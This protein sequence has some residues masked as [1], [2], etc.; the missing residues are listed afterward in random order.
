MKKNKGIKDLPQPKIIRFRQWKLGKRWLYGAFVLTVL[1]GGVVMTELMNSSLI[2]TIAHA[3]ALPSD[4]TQVGSIGTSPV[5]KTSNT[6]WTNIQKGVDA[7]TESLSPNYYV[8]AVDSDGK[9][10]K[11]GW[12]NG[13]TSYAG[14]SLGSLASANPAD[15]SIPNYNFVKNAI[16]SRDGFQ[17]VDNF[18]YINGAGQ[19][20]GIHNVGQAFEVS[21]GKYV[22]IG[23]KITIN[24]ATYY[25]SPGA[26]TPRDVFGDGYK[27]MVAARNDGSGN[28]TLG[29]VVVMTGVQAVDSGGGSEGGGL[30]GGT[31]AIYGGCTLGIPRM[32]DATVTY[33]NEE[34][35]QALPA[36]SLSVVKVADVDA[37]QAAATD[38]N[39]ALGY[40]I[41]DPT[42][43]TLKDNI[44]TASTKNTISQD[45]PTLSPNSYVVVKNQNSFKLTFDDTLGNKLQ[46]S[47]IQSLFGTQGPT[48]NPSSYL[49]LDKTT[50]QYGDKFPNNNYGFTNLKFQV[51]NKDGKV[52]DTLTLNSTGRS[53]KS[54]PLSPGDYLLHEISDKWSSTGQTQ[55]SDVKV[56]VSG[57]KTTTVS[58]KN[59]TNDA[60]Q[61]QISIVKKGV[62]SGTNLWNGNYS[63][64]GN[65]FKITKLDGADK[66]TTYTVTTNKDGKAKTD[67]IPLGKYHV[68]EIK[69][70]NGFVLT[71]KP[72]DV[73]LTYKDNKTQLVFDE[74]VGTNQEVKGQFS[75]S[76][77]DKETGKNQDGKAVMK[78]AKYQLFYNDASTGS[79]PHKKGD[80]VKWGD[81]PKA[82][83]QIGN[84]VTEMIIN[85]NVVKTGDNVVI[86]MEDNTLH[87]GVGNLAEGEYYVQEVDAGEG[88]TVDSTKY[89]FEITK[90]D[91]QTANIVVPGLTSK[92]QAIKAKISF[93]KLAETAGAASNGS[94]YNGVEFTFTPEEGTIADPIKVTTGVNPATDEDGYGATQLVYGDWKMSETK[95]I[96]GYDKIPDIYIH[97]SHDTK[98]DLLTIT[99]STNEDGSKPFSTRTYN[100][101]DNSSDKNPNDE[102]NIVVGD[103]TEDNPFVALSKMSLT[104]KPETPSEVPKPSIDIEKTNGKEVPQAGN[105]N[106][107]DKDNN[108]GENDHDTEKSA[109]IIQK[110]KITDISGLITNNGK[111]ALSHILF[112]DKTLMGKVNVGEIKV[113]YKGKMLTV[114]DKGEF[115][116]NGK[117]LVLQ[118]KETLEIHG[119]LPALSAGEIHGDEF[120]VTAVGVTSNETVGDKDKW[121]AKTPEEKPSIDIE[122]SN[123]AYPTA[124]QGNNTDK[125]NN[126]GPNDHDTKETFATIDN[127]KIPIFFKVTNNGSENL[128][129]VTPRDQT[130]EGNVKVEN[131]MWT[132]NGKTLKEASDGS[133]ETTDG[134]ALTLKPGEVILG[135][136]ELPKLPKGQL[137][138]DKVTVTAIGEKSGKKVSDSDKWYGKVTT[139]ISSI[140]NIFLPRTGEATEHYL[141]RLGM[142]LLAFSLFGGGAEIIKDRY[143]SK[144]SVANMK[145]E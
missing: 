140:V 70:S 50:A 85:G 74:A 135:K 125:D 106:Y 45:K 40:F 15:L 77:E 120:T 112:G 7:L 89:E 81:T 24:D 126:A 72:V 88:Y 34:M 134:K 5:Y 69:A 113:T 13:K 105:G 91:D 8:G 98:T 141:A 84:K 29:Y 23:I 138:G 100:V 4:F 114:N 44:L 60:V 37:G 110:D 145:D 71:F 39:G 6:A 117:L 11:V 92:E 121:Y 59:L 107:S 67:K 27:L 62:E 75:L 111:E 130:I 61:G 35:G 109:L 31:G 3:T 87:I 73:E 95:G 123:V 103:T 30:G 139:V 83:L 104:N 49:Q 142:T 19:Y 101:T 42:N 76:K 90:K 38:S 55:R 16:M 133:L 86:D 2:Q 22:P 9:G 79:S 118:P 20:V 57:G 64:A 137:H 122:K 108:V 53:P 94:G 102:G 54:K 99:A 12:Y 25:D 93:Q 68:E 65:Q 58:G 63:L 52:V 129:K 51:I 66:G 10:Q 43:L 21:S 144:K 96:E 1:V 131:I 41:S 18:N 127:T 28:I 116:L 115:L 36:N 143:F 78:D 97:M 48:L 136:G 17:D 46:G 132:F 80:P 47:I 26:T 14:A 56:H 119:L 128:N 33:V 82:Q 124:G 32:I